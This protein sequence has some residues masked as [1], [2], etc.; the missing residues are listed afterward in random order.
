MI[1][2]LCGASCRFPGA[3]LDCTCVSVLLKLTNWIR[4]L[5]R[6]GPV[7]ANFPL[8]AAGAVWC[9]F[10]VL[11]P[12]FLW[13]P[14]FS[15]EVARRACCSLAGLPFLGPMFVGL[16]MICDRRLAVCVFL[17]VLYFWR[18]PFRCCA[19]AGFLSVLLVTCHL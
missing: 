2:G 15:C 8:Y 12:A 16:G 3:D 1:S 5:V 13:V 9:G 7:G 19:A 17:L 11:C 6:L 14:G 18:L 10:W 4:G